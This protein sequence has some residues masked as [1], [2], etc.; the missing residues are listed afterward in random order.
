MSMIEKMVER[1]EERF[2]DLGISFAEGNIPLVDINA[3]SED[4]LF[5]YQREARETLKGFANCKNLKRNYDARVNQAYD[6]LRDNVDK[7][8][9]GVTQ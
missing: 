2:S 7:T 4:L 1:I 3:T 9:V 5:R 6:R 8:L